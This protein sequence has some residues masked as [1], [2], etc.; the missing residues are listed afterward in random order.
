[1]ESE[2]YQMA[3]RKLAGVPETDFR[4]LVYEFVA[5]CPREFLEAMGDN[6]PL[7]CDLIRIFRESN[8]S[9]IPL[10]KECRLR[11]GWGLKEAKDYVEALLERKGLWNQ[12]R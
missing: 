9:L 4:R 5:R 12:R 11:T 1:M 3:I 6:D 8:N 2:I 7:D 10:I